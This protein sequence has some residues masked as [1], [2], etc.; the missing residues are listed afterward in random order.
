MDTAEGAHT[1]SSCKECADQ[2]DDM[3]KQIEEA[4]NDNA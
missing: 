4:R 1:V 3:L 2:F